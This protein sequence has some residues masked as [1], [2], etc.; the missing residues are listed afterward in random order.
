MLVRQVEIQPQGREIPVLT[1][2]VGES[3]LLQVGIRQLLNR[4]RRIRGVANVG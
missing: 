2:R 1:T 4:A 3:E